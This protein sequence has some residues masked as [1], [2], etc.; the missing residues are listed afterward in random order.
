MDGRADVYS[1]GCVLFECLT[2][3]VPFPRDREV[4][5]LWAYIGENPPRVTAERDDVS[6]GV[7]HVVARA[8]AKDPVDRYPTAAALAE[9]LRGEATA[10]G[11]RP[12]RRAFRTSKQRR[13][14]HR[15]FIAT[16]ATVLTITGTVLYFA[17]RP[18]PLVVPQA[19]SLSRLDAAE[20]R[21]VESRAV[22][23]QPIGLAVGD[24]TVWTI[25]QGRNTVQRVD[26]D[27]LEADPVTVGVQGAPRGLAVGEG[28][29]MGHD[30]VHDGTERDDPVPDEPG[31]QPARSM[32]RYPLRFADG[33]S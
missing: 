31:N 25:N 29:A 23:E 19:N 27:D 14:T 22:L 21:F 7:D 18:P 32:D 5:T 16:V 2:G 1:L 30:R 24:G 3:H 9:D 13:R 20:R 4:A 28:S 17:T 33:R 10:L 6:A 15:V 11:A 12:R 8:M 26:P